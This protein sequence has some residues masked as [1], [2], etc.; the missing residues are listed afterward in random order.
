MESDEGSKKGK[1]G[2]GQSGVS[3]RG[4]PRG[5]GQGRRERR[6]GSLR[7]SGRKVGGVRPLRYACNI[8]AITY[9]RKDFL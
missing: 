3:G 7:R 4:N 5:R 1:E 2:S 8:I 9:C 6:E